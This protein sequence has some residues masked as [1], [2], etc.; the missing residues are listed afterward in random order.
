VGERKTV[1]IDRNEERNVGGL[2]DTLSMTKKTGTQDAGGKGKK[3]V[4]GRTQQKKNPTNSLRLGRKQG[5]KQKN[6][7]TGKNCHERE[8]RLAE[9]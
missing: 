3:E 6:P 4:R 7:L 9:E 2:K 8:E 1:L 5:N